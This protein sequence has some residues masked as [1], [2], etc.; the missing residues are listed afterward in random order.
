MKDGDFK[1][2]KN[3]ALRFLSTEINISESR[4]KRSFQIKTSNLTFER[5]RT[6]TFMFFSKCIC[7]Q[8]LFNK[9]AIYLHLEGEFLFKYSEI[10]SSRCLVSKS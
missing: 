9:I 7:L 5:R 3:S 10:T 6:K 8:Y 4:V 1:T 2:H